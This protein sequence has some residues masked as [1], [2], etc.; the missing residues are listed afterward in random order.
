MRALSLG[1]RSKPKQ[2]NWPQ[3]E[4]TT[5][6]RLGRFLLQDLLPSIV[7]VIIVSLFALFIGVKIDQAKSSSADRMAEIS[8]LP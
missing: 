1:H 4:P 3:A 8:R 7:M 5:L 2:S 6:Q